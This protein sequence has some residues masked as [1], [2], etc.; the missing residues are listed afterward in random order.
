MLKKKNISVGIVKLR[1]SFNN[2]IVS[3]TDAAGNVVE[4]A[5][6][7]SC[8]FKGSKKSTPYAAQVTMQKAIEKA[9]ANGLKVV[10]VHAWGPGA[11]R[12]SALRALSGFDKLNVTFIADVTTMPHN[13]C[14]P[15]KRRRV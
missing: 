11:G 4:W 8:G 2:T 1:C 3:I 12:E 15:P 9:V 14:R 10:Q 5:S 7:G 13:G 6:A